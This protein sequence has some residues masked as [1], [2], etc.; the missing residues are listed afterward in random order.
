M[1]RTTKIASISAAAMGGLLAGSAAL[2]TSSNVAI[3]GMSTSASTVRISN[4][5]N[6]VKAVTLDDSTTQPA[7]HDCK[8]Q[9]DCKGMGGCKSS[10]NGCKGKNDCKGK[11]GCS[12]AMAD[13][14]ATTQPSDSTSGT[15]M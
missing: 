2:A 15:G 3:S 5:I 14:S 4:N 6:G 10:D 7:K 9:N 1:S 11:G 13:K 8:G 12:S